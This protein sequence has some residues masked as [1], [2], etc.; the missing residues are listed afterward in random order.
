MGKITEC[1]QILMRTSLA[2]MSE[3]FRQVRAFFDQRYSR[4]WNEYLRDFLQDLL[5]DHP[6]D[7]KFAKDSH[8]V[9]A[10]G[11]YRHQAAQNGHPIRRPG[12][13]R[14]HPARRTS[15]SL[16]DNLKRSSKSRE[17]LDSIIT[18]VKKAVAAEIGFIATFDPIKDQFTLWGQNDRRTGT[19]ATDDYKSI[20]NCVNRAHESKQMVFRLANSGQL[21]SLVCIPISGLNGSFFYIVL[22]NK[23]TDIAFSCRDV[24]KAKMIA[25]NMICALRL[26]FRF[27]PKSLAAIT[28]NNSLRTQLN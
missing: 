12:Y 4:Q 21:K 5:S 17:L 20:R 26:Y 8:I 3:T 19:F 16:L 28:N 2:R 18:R 11:T 1:V 24:Q 7:G 9:P 6:I 23:K 15:S 25:E 27:E 14:K 10:P 22:A 13:N